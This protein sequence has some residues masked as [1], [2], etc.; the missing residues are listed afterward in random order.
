M[1]SPLSW[2]IGK[3]YV[4][5]TRGKG[6]VS[7]IS[8]ISVIGVALGVIALIVVLSVMNGV[9]GEVKEKILAMT[10]HAKLTAAWRGNTIPADYDV[11]QY[12]NNKEVLA[13]A[14]F[15]EGQGLIALQSTF[16]PVL[17][18]GIDPALESTVSEAMLPI[19]SELNQ[20]S[21]NT[22]NII[23]GKRIADMMGATVGDKITVIIP[24]ASV[25]AAGM[26]PRL[27]RFT[28]VGVFESGHYTYDSSLA[29]INLADATKL[30]QLEDGY[31]GYQLKL[32]DP[33]NAPQISKQLNQE[34]E[35]TPLIV[36]DW[37]D[38]NRNYFEAV[39]VE[40]A[41]MFFILMVIVIVAAINILSVLVMV[42]TDK[43]KDIAILRTL[44]VSPATITKI[45]VIQ[46]TILGVIGTVIGVIGGILISKNVPVIMGL[47]E[48]HFGIQLPAELYFISHLNPRI[49]ADL[50]ALIA[51]CAI[52]ISILFTIPP[53]RKAAKTHP[54]R[55]LAY[56]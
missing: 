21:A 50:V 42:V 16:L 55:A 53:A 19:Q 28:V 4:T 18:K 17:I 10:A 43:Q 25:T 54:A 29:L 20:L 47:L 22:F 7:F 26:Q 46:G 44:G 15:T 41:A 30:F 6:F 32:S 39:K 13:Y 1:S 51:V 8:L 5:A 3:R 49:D 14:P 23:I 45:F 52:I 56:E 31:Q 37:T 2:Y 38:E 33:I 35:N 48:K 11:S 12:L 27:K 36:R 9:T 40:K 24:K 34:L